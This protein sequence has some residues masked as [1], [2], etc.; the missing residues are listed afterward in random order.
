MAGVA[1]LLDPLTV[2]WILSS[3]YCSVLFLHC[4]P[5]SCNCFHLAIGEY[6]LP[7]TLGSY[8]P[9][10]LPCLT[11]L[12]AATSYFTPNP[13]PIHVPSLEGMGTSRIPPCNWSIWKINGRLEWATQRQSQSRDARIVCMCAYVSTLSTHIS[14]YVPPD[15]NYQ[16]LVKPEG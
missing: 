11:I 15:V 4:W 12:L 8:S 5:L 14:M 16:N 2:H 7:P 3:L 6:E 9:R 1:E 13:L 10:N